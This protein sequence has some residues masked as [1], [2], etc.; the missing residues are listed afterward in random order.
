M[1][2]ADGAVPDG[3]GEGGVEAWEVG[4]LDADDLGRVGLV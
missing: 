4:G 1:E 3:G 2:P